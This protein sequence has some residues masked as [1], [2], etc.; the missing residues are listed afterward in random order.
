MTLTSDGHPRVQQPTAFH[1]ETHT[2]PA[3]FD[4][5]ELI[6]SLNNYST[7]RQDLPRRAAT[8]RGAESGSGGD[9]HLASV[10]LLRIDAA[11]DYFTTDRELMRRPEPVL[12]DVIL[13]PFVLNILPRTLLPTVGYVVLVAAA[14]WV[15]AT[16]LLMPWVR[17]LMVDE[18][19]DDQHGTG[20]EAGA[21]EK[22]TR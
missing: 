13:D 9:H 14:S 8:A 4:T 1:L 19:G 2:L 10:L 7:S 15:L 16:R 12:A 20:Q 5:P 18:G 22:K 6:T 21:E 3:V 11:A 17:G